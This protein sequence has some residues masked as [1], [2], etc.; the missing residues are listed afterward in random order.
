MYPLNEELENLIDLFDADLN[1]IADKYNITRSELNKQFNYIAQ[2][3]TIS[4]YIFDFSNSVITDECVTLLS[5]N[6]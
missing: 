5:F 4:Y 3:N 2:V 6:L 1:L